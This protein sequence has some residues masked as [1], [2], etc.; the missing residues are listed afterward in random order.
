MSLPR[1]P[2]PGRPPEPG[3]YT[4][5]CVHTMY[6]GVFYSTWRKCDQPDIDA[7]EIDTDVSALAQLRFE[8]AQPENGTEREWIVLPLDVL[9]SSLVRVQAARGQFRKV[10]R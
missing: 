1:Q 6:F 8:S 3:L 2:A 10:K 5:L 4:R 9:R 7:L